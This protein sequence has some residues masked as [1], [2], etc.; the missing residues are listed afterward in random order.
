MLL[1]SQL[2]TRPPNLVLDYHR[3]NKITT[4]M[5]LQ[6]GQTQLKT[7]NCYNFNG[8]NPHFSTLTGHGKEARFK[9]NAA[10]IVIQT[11]PGYGGKY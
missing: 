4:D 2:D 8:H 9:K 11:Q 3:V 1:Q 5:Q 7:H 6:P 10:L